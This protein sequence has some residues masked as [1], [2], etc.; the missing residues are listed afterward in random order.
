[1]NINKLI[2]ILFLLITLPVLSQ[3]NKVHVFNVQKPKKQ[4]IID[5]D[6][7]ILLYNQ[8]NYIKINNA[9]ELA[10]YDVIL[11]GGE[12]DFKDN[13]LILKPL[14]KD[15]VYLRLIPLVE[16]GRGGSPSQTYI[17]E[18]QIDKFFV[19]DKYLPFIGNQPIKVLEVD[20]LTEKLISQEFVIKTKH[21][22][23]I[24]SYEVKSFK[25]SYGKD[26][27][28]HEHK[29]IGN[30]LTKKLIL[31]MMNNKHNTYFVDDFRIV[32]NSKVTAKVDVLGI[33]RADK[34][35]HNIKTDE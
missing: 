23:L 3:N 18:I 32:I 29:I 5:L 10:K 30:R 1:M 12:V 26:G 16:Y 2:S 7:E 28:Y 22:D 31:F 34:L 33:I 21:K 24:K 35:Y 9:K 14:V 25:L 27:G 8:P 4:T 13:F 15:S 20:G 19:I 6:Y 11:D 17:K